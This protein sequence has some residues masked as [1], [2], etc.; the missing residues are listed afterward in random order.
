MENKEQQL[1][2]EQN[3]QE[4]ADIERARELFEYEMTE[5]LLNFQSEVKSMKR[6]DVS[7]YLDMELP[8]AGIDYTAPEIGVKG[9]DYTDEGINLSL[10]GQKLSAQPFQPVSGEIAE[11]P[12]VSVDTAAMPS[13][14]VTKPP[15][16]VEEMPVFDGNVFAAGIQ[17]KVAVQQP[18][19]AAWAIPDVKMQTAVLA[20]GKVNQPQIALT[21]SQPGAVSVPL[22]P[23]P[24]A[25]SFP[26]VEVPSDMNRTVSLPVLSEVTLSSEGMD[27]VTVPD[28]SPA[29]VTAVT[30]VSVEIKKPD[31]LVPMQ[32][33]P[34]VAMPELPPV[35]AAEAAAYPAIPEKPDFSMYYTD[36]MQSLKAEI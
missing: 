25:V 28:A 13:L 20:A 29:K 30:A 36:I 34:V 32:D 26:A 7:E 5:V 8:K 24:A 19:A 23:K 12:A 9:I 2:V 16:T 10:N 1:P 33:S 31:N 3:E 18:D 27:G 6:R 22:M 14:T 35:K 21:V 4:L 17:K 15:L 11:V